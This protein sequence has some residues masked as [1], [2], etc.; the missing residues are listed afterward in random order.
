VY[1]TLY[2]R[3]L[4]PKA[5][6]EAFRKV[7]RSKGAPGIDGQFVDQFETDL[8]T[9][10]HPSSY[11]YRPGRGC[12]Q[13]ISKAQMFIRLYEMPYV[14]DMDLSKC[15]DRLDHELIIRQVRTRVRDGSILR[16]LRQFLESGVMEESSVPCWQTSIWTPL[17]NLPEPGD[18]G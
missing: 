16:L 12:H 1:Y 6:V 4:E 7:K 13:A 5:L 17:I 10:F 11:G 18:T 2:G 8:G 15:F 3:L 9:L 14:V